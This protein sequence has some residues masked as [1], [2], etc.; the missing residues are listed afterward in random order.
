MASPH[1]VA[2]LWES[3]DEHINSAA[4]PPD[5]IGVAGRITSWKSRLTGIISQ[6]LAGLESASPTGQELELNFD[7][8]HYLSMVI[9]LL[10]NNLV[11]MYP[12]SHEV[13]ISEILRMTFTFV[14]RQLLL[15]LLHSHLPS[16]KGTWEKLLLGAQK[17]QNEEAFKF[18]ITI[19]MDNDW[20]D[21]NDKGHDYLFS[22][23]L[24]NCFNILCALIDR[25]CRI[26][27]SQTWPH[28]G[29]IIVRV[30]ENGNL[31][32]ARL[33]IR[34]F[35]VNHEFH[36]HIHK[37]TH[38]S[39]FIEEFDDTRPEHLYCL[40]LFL[41]QGA[42][43]DYQINAE[44]IYYHVFS[45]CWPQ[46]PWP[47][48]GSISGKD[49]LFS[50]L[51]RVYYFH[52]SLFPRLATYSGAK[53]QFSRARAL[54]H[55]DQGID[56]LRE[57][58]ASDPDLP[59]PWGEATGN[60]ADKANTPERKN[61]CLEVLLVEQLLLSVYSREGNVSWSRVKALSEL[62]ID[63]TELSKTEE[64]LAAMILFAT[65][66]LITSEDEPYKENW[67]QV[68]QWLL[69]QG[70]RV[71]AEALFA[72]VNQSEGAI[73]E[74]LVSFCDDLDNEG[75]E[76]L[77]YAAE[78]NKFD[79]TKRLLDRG[80]DPNFTRRDCTV[81]EAAVCGSSLDVMEYLV[82][83]GAK[84]EVR[85]QGDRVICDLMDV[86]EFDSEEDF[87]GWF[88][89]VLYIIEKYIMIDE[90]SCLSAHLLEKCIHGHTFQI[91]K[92][93][94]IFESLLSKGARLSPG[95]PLAAW[96]AAGGRHQL[97]HEMLDAGADPNAYS[98]DE[99]SPFFGDHLDCQTP[100]QAAAEIGDYTLVCMLI[101]HGA[102]V[103]R[104]AVGEYGMTA[105]QAIHY[106]DPVRREE[107][108]QKEKIIKL[109]LD[110]GADVNAA[111]SDGRT[112]LHFASGQ[113]DISSAFRLLKHRANINMS[114]I[115]GEFDHCGTALD[116]AARSG[117]L[118]MVDFLLNANALSSS[119]CSD[120]KDYDRAIELARKKGHFVVSELIRKHSADRKRWDVPP[121]QAV[122]T[123]FSP[124]HTPESLS[125]KAKSGTATWPQTER[126]VTPSENLQYVT[127][128]DHTNRQ[129]YA[130]EEGMA[131]SGT[132][133]SKAKGNGMSGAE[134]TGMSWPRVIEEIEDEPPVANSGSEE[135]RGEESDG[136]ANQALNTNKAA[137]ELGGWSYQ[138]IE[139]NW[140]E[141]EQQNVDPLVSSSLSTDVFMGFSE[142]SSP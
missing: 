61:Y 59:G 33:L 84:P 53:F 109:F 120:G 83:R 1:T 7:S 40:E 119:A 140:V 105:I 34:H 101:E 96:I 104:P 26:D 60:D 32:C 123:N 127:G 138:P 118:D 10:S 49:W 116:A 17:L 69:N 64:L 89:K 126:R 139:Q 36:D 30:L 107:R 23:A 136:T 71:K 98:N 42:D 111:S 72:G 52:R 81:Y 103:N 134:A 55:L 22:A 27:S 62:E 75:G 29:S 70:F 93:R 137:C 91:E 131:E 15:A 92:R 85:K 9:Y 54:W 128:L 28:P 18:L 41:E 2:R 78:N 100:L 19:G 21:E 46:E 86:Y 114:T 115:A 14:S 8:H 39:M 16:I 73:L 125:L 94:G 12:S 43:V 129:S 79:A 121:R 56:A 57:Y 65:A 38:F 58:L 112:A 135:F 95:S 88:N 108:L 11:S 6:L 24:M 37:A 35:D 113:G 97:V 132:A 3:Q 63:L 141:D 45:M 31:D 76:A 20:L 50:I 4:S 117:R 87:D 5:N 51:D 130:F 67:L 13:D 102:D 25:G 122:E 82:Q 99:N 133:A 106:W 80:V 48:C 142:F 47:G 74:C 110:K 90:A 44:S 68:L 77:L 66:F 124:E